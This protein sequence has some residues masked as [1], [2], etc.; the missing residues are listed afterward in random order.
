MTPTAPLTSASSAKCNLAAR[1]TVP[2]A[3]A[4]AS[5]N[6]A[7]APGG[8]G[9]VGA[10]DDVGANT[11]T[12]AVRSPVRAAA[13]NAEGTRRLRPSSAA[14]SVGVPCILWRAAGEFLRGERCAPAWARS[15][16]RAR[17][18]CR[19][20]RT[21]SVRPGSACSAPRAALGSPSRPATPP[22]PGGCPGQDRRG[23]ARGVVG[24]HLAPGCQLNSPSATSRSPMAER[25]GRQSERRRRP[26]VSLGARLLRS[27]PLVCTSDLADQLGAEAVAT[28]R[29][30]RRW[31]V[32]AG[33]AHSVPPAPPGR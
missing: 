28:R 19:A 15:G 9:G 27:S 22:L 23:P 33:R 1:A 14:G 10:A 8:S 21:L 5:R 31:V 26:Q 20:A 7:A 25:S 16:R 29:L 24:Q 30:V 11:A 3:T 17:R 32:R 4:C 13:S 12:I 6:F 2:F 18:T